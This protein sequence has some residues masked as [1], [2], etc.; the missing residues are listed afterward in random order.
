M[1]K[2]FFFKSRFV[3]YQTANVSKLVNTFSQIDTEA[4][5]TDRKQRETA[6][7]Y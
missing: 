7:I 5:L 2:V 1:I 4:R 6:F 3:L